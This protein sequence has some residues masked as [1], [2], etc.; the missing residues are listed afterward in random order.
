[1]CVLVVLYVHCLSEFWTLWNCRSLDISIH[2][3]KQPIHWEASSKP[4]QVSV[5]E[6]YFRVPCKCCSYVILLF[7]STK[8]KKKSGL[9]D[10]WLSLCC[11]VMSRNV[12][13]CCCLFVPSI[14]SCVRITKMERPA[15]FWNQTLNTCISCSKRDD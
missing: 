11:I 4:C 13:W 8:R 9:W 6:I 10:I 2:K 1:M 5:G 12:L 3:I 7:C 14:V 15:L